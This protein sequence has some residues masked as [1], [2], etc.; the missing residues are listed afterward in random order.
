MK[1]WDDQSRLKRVYRSMRRL[2]LVYRNTLF[3]NDYY[4]LYNK[5]ATITMNRWKIFSYYLS[6]LKRGVIKRP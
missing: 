6:L 2:L 5:L 1:L 4:K 3:N